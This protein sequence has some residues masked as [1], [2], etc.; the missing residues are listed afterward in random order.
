MTAASYVA[1]ATVL[2]CL[3]AACQINEYFE[4]DIDENELPQGYVHPSMTEHFAQELKDAFDE[5]R[6]SVICL[7][8]REPTNLDVTAHGSAGQISGS[9]A[10]LEL[11]PELMVI[12]AKATEWRAAVAI[13]A[14]SPNRST[15]NMLLTVGVIASAALFCYVC[16]PT[17]V[18]SSALVAIGSG[19]A[20]RELLKERDIAN[21]EL[22]ANRISSQDQLAGGIR[23]LTAQ[24]NARKN[25]RLFLEMRAPILGQLYARPNG[26]SYL[27]FNRLSDQIA[28]AKAAYNSRFK[29]SYEPK[30]EE[31]GTLSDVFSIALLEHSLA[32]YIATA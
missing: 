1:T 25:M 10:T 24:Q 5:K 19:L 14:L 26:D 30:K 13:G 20:T 29:E 28:E 12:D 2:H 32:G 21:G 18:V 15:I 23:Y 11:N 3:N 6:V 16:A 4:D 17:W 22:F 7:K 27:P 9:T 31:V 8:S